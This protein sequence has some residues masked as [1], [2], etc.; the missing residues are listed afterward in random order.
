MK[1]IIA[2]GVF[3]ALSA[4][5]VADKNP[6]AEAETV[7]SGITFDEGQKKRLIESSLKT[8]FW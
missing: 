4:C 3:L 2:T 6:E 5:M 7:Q 1:H 8:L